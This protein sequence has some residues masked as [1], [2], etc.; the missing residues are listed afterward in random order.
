MGK[1][2]DPWAEAHRMGLT[3][4][5]RRLRPGHRGEYWHR[6]R[7]IALTSGMTHREARSVLAHEIQ[8]ALAGDMFSPFGPVNARQELLARRATARTLIDPDEYAAAEAIRGPHL[9]SIAHD[10][11]VT[12][13]V[14]RDWVALRRALVAA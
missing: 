11:D 8:H 10:L 9:A 4:V 12:I 6:D 1:A 2:Y 14:V 5:E 7:L 3:V 13:H